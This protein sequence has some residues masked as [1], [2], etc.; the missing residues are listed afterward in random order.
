[1]LNRDGACAGE[2]AREAPPASSRTRG[3]E[4]VLGRGLRPAKGGNS[5]SKHMR[6]EQPR[7]ATT[8]HRINIR[9]CPLEGDASASDW[10]AL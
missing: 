3:C 5:M 1:M 4:C 8:E 2:L 7:Q 6:Y 9:N 10:R